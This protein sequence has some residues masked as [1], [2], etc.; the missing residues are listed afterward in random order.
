[1]SAGATSAAASRASLE[2]ALARPRNQWAMMTPLLPL[3]PRMLA[4]AASLETSPRCGS[5]MARTAA[6]VAE[7]DSAM[8]VP[9]SPSGTGNTLMRLICSRVCR[10]QSAPATMA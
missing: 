7:R 2:K 3:A 9:V 1:M 8:L 4:S 6:A 10:T 5:S